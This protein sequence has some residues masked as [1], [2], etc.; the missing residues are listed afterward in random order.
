MDSTS[1]GSK[2]YFSGGL[3]EIVSEP[4]S[5][6]FSYLQKWF[7]GAS[8]FGIAMHLL[9][10]PYLKT[11]DSILEIIDG[12][13]LINLNTE[14]A[15]IYKNTIFTYKNQKSRAVTPSLKISYTKLLNPICIY[16][17]IKI[18]IVQSKWI[19]KPQYFAKKT[20]GFIEK[21]PTKI[22]STNLDEIN[23]NLMDNVWPYVIA[24]GIL[25]EF[26]DH[27]IK[28]EAKDKY[29]QIQQYIASQVSQDDWYFQCL[30]DQM[31][32]KESQLTFDSYIN[33]Y[34]LRADDDY[35]LT[36]PR[37]YE[38]KSTIQKRIINIETSHDKKEISIPSGL[39]NKLLSY[40]KAEIRLQLARSNTKRKALT[41]IDRLR[42]LLIEK[43]V[44]K[45]LP[46]SKIKKA[47][48]HSPIS[49]PN[50]QNIGTPVSLGTATGIAKVITTTQDT[51]DK[52]T[53]GVFPNASPQF[54]TLYTKC[55]GMIFLKGGQTSH[56]AIVAREFGIPAIVD[57]Q[58]QNIKNGTS[59]T[60]DGQSGEWKI[61]S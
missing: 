1:N 17:T 10:L 5:I 6:T 58:A 42:Q 16:N 39:S 9:G 11:K 13:L 18:L 14:E 52:N 3:A 8:S 25:T 53:I 26:F 7:N 29:G 23:S 47:K 48:K 19:A 41:A 61:N 31:K 50:L 60:L 28:S 57:I 43:D 54:S 21:I 36:S 30:S 59:I 37:W 34:G 51:I 46:I 33:S 20:E 27:L 24:T 12:Q 56:G 32:V 55:K 45:K 40:I 44:I 38:I 22:Y 2:N 15:T 35:E 49:S 4:S